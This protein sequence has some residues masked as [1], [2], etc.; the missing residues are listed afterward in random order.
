MVRSG[1]L[2]SLLVLS[3]VRNCGLLV[4]VRQE[5]RFSP[6]KEARTPR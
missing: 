6:G 3:G 4:A 5:P 1:V 2:A